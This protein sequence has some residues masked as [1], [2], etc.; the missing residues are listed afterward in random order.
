[1]ECGNILCTCD[2]RLF[3]KLLKRKIPLQMVVTCH[4]HLRRI[5]G[6]QG[7]VRFGDRSSFCGLFGQCFSK[8]SWLVYGSRYFNL[9]SQLISFFHYTDVIMGTIASQ[10]TSITIVNSTFYSDTD[11]RK[12]QSSASLAFVRGI[13]RIPV[14]SLHK[15]SVTRKMFPFDDVIMRIIGAFRHQ[16]VKG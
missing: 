5:C 10:I 7:Q 15:W 11:Q 14:N 2:H 9:C 12:Y 3:W 8:I 6:K 1:M 16:S 4:H 13:H